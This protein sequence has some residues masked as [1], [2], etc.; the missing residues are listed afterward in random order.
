MRIEIDDPSLIGELSSFLEGCQCDVAAVRRRSIEA[1][2]S[3]NALDARLARLQL[4]G[5]L[6][7]WQ[8]MHPGVS[9]KA[10]E[11][12]DAARTEP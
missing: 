4:E 8:A 11:R 5:F 10:F 12:V 6:H 7:A 9:V 2:P 1:S 3:A